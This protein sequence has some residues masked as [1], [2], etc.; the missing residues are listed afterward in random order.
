M[1]GIWNLDKGFLK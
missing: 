1:R